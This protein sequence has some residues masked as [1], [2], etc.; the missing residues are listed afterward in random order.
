MTVSYAGLNGLK[1]VEHVALH[2]D[3]LRDTVHHNSI[4]ERYQVNPSAT[5]L[6][7]SYRTKLM[8]QGANLISNLIKELGRE[9]SCTYAGTICLEDT[10]DLA[11]LIGSYTQTCASTCTNRVRGGDKGV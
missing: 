10:I 9:W 4:L 11:N 1:C 2:H 6:A 8:A 7:A 5:T 3:E